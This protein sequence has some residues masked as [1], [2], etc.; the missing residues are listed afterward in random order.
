LATKE[1][2]DR[3]TALRTGRRRAS[4]IGVV[5][6]L[7]LSMLW[8]GSAMADPDTPATS[9]QAQQAYLDSSQRAGALNEEVLVAQENEQAASAAVTAAAGQVQ[10]ATTAAADAKQRAATADQEAAGYQAKVDAFANASF[11]G[12][13]LSQMSVLLTADSAEDFLDQVSSLDRVAADTQQTLEAAVAAKAAAGQAQSDAAATQAAAEKSKTDADAAQVSAQQATADV[14]ARKAG[15]EA[16]AVRYKALYDSLSAQE[17]QAAE[18]AAEA[19]NAAANAAAAAAAPAAAAPAAANRSEV[20]TP[21]SADP[22]PAAQAPAEESSAEPE[23]SEEPASA[24][25][26]NSAAARAVAAALSKEGS[27]YVYGA[28]GPSSFDCSGLTSW[29]WA[30][31]GV[32]IPRTSGGQAGLPSVPL[33]ELQPG[34]LVT[35]YSPVHHVAMYI[36]GGQIIHASTESKP[37]YIT[38]VSG[39]GPNATGHRVG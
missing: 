23:P 14:S 30:Q 31:A 26:G 18:A 21:I 39:G 22:A 29:A 8:T 25:A 15:L 37:V 19:A 7:S 24:P 9:D 5:A 36:G 28:A 6:A 13:R 11:R 12:A 33:S 34:D 10:A 38:T 27:R 2:G 3:P 4:V 1:L 32:S 35:Y 16:E 17:R 20:R